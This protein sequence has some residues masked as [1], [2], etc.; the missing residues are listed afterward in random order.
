MSSLEDGATATDLAQKLQLLRENWRTIGIATSV[1]VAL[2]IVTAFVIPPTYTAEASFIPPTTGSAGL[3]ALAGQLSE[4]GAGGAIAA[5]RNASELYVGILGSSSIAHRLIARFD[6]QHVYK[7]KKESSAEKILAS[8]SNFEAGLRDGI[9]TLRISDHSPQ[10]A[11]DLAEGYLEE[12]HNTTGRLALTEAAQRRLFFEQQLAK[13][14]DSLADAEV[15]LERIEESTG[16]ISGGG[17]TSISLQTIAQTRASIA[18]REVELAALRQGSTDQRADVV[19]LRSE[20]A[21][22]QGKLADLQKG[23]GA[24]V[25]DIPKSKMPELMLQEVRQERE[26]KYHE[27]LF[28]MIAKQYEDARL[29]ESRDSPVLQVLDYPMVPDAKS[30]PPRKLIVLCGL[31]L[32]VLLGCAW[33]LYRNWASAT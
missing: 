7:V 24:A 2:S 10:R 30:G 26:V 28:D 4:A 21:D 11:R 23:G 32:G 25:V 20:I 9:V 33:V 27:T 12:L 16:L 15:E 22:L 5:I 29:D 31:I 19:S 3:S 18:A 13:E 1:A 17:Q 6:L 8:N 14:K